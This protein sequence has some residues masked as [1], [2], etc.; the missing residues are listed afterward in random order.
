MGILARRGIVGQ[1]CPTY[2]SRSDEALVCLQ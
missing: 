1:E 2:V